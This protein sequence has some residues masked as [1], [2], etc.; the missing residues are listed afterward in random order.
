[1]SP[2]RVLAWLALASLLALAGCSAIQVGY[3]NAD[4]LIHWRAGRYFD[5][6]GDTKAE[7]ER[8]VQRFL[9][10]HRKTELPRY[11]VFA[12]EMADRL[13]RGVSQADLVWGYDSLQS[14]L[15]QSVRAGAGEIAD[16]LDGLTPAQLERFQQRLEKE[17][18]DYAKEYGLRQAPEERRARRVKRNIERMEDWFGTLTD[19]QVERIAAYAKRAPLDDQ[20]RDRDRRRLQRELLAMLRAK[21]A[22]KRLAQWSVAWDQNRE[23][24]FE[25]QRSANLQ[26]YYGML[27]D[28]DKTLTPEQRGRAVKRLRSFAADFSALAAAAESPR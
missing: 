9:A 1:V 17:N 18:S 4:T 11:A 21:E 8:R 15:R 24:A 25:A 26:E 12:N 28:L 6:E 3:N 27:L 10:W 5:F 2:V 23:P 16:L 14:H 20:L 13:A 7:F 19:A 22:R